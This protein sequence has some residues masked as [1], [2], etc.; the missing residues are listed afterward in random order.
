MAG[1]LEPELKLSYEIPNFVKNRPRTR[2]VCT[3]GPATRTPAKVE[4]LVRHGMSVARLNLSH[5]SRT[6]HQS[7]VDTVR[8]VS[9]KLGVTIGILAD[10]PG[11][12]YRVGVMANNDLELQRNARF[13]LYAAPRRGTIEGVNVWPVGLHSDVKLNAKIL[14]D[15][16]NVELRVVEVSGQD[17]VCR[18]TRG[19][20]LKD[21]K[22]VTAP[23]N[24]STL[25][26]FTDETVAA[27]QFA[28]DVDVDFIGLSYIRDVT[29]LERVK[30]RVRQA[31]R[32]CLLVSK[33]EIKQAVDN[34]DSILDA[35]DAVMVA[36]GDLGVELP[37]EMVPGVQ[38]RII[39]RAN[40]RGKP[41]ITATQMLES[42]IESS[43]PT[44]AEAT[45]VH[46][47]VRDGT[48]AIMLSGETS[49]GRHPVRVVQY[50][51]R[52]AKRAEKFLDYA[53]LANR[54][55]EYSARRNYGVGDA[56]AYSAVVTGEA[57]GAKVILAFTESGTTPSRVAAFRPRVPVISLSRSPGVGR[58]LSLRWGIV[59]L[60]VPYFETVQDMFYEGSEL[61]I[62]TGYA[63]K[64][65]IA[66]AVV[67]M[68][69]GIGGSTNLLRVITLP[70]PI[71]DVHRNEHS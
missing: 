36:R 1:G 25:D 6:D 11:P 62:K 10:L 44:R 28:L 64:G 4:Q 29:D 39:R 50:M 54:R 43:S 16:G 21:N 5:G 40:E 27:L 26:Y 48:D 15:E 51:A 58:R 2:I 35:S 60:I 9:E 41:V 34:L 45:D 68:P 14:L 18:V 56:I 42:M 71:S 7:L 32:S 38:K 20:P 65:E 31:G 52:I 22:A 8:Q 59:P 70:E 46:N 19:G 55:L 53:Q 3:I 61:A 69:I 17:I 24:T 57:L 67:G 66:I 33:I 47:A 37:I 23:G 13:T 63:K 30:E 49:V 12:K